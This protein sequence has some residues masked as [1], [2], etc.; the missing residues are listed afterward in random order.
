MILG[1]KEKLVFL[2]LT[3]ETQA[4][5]N[6]QRIPIS[7]SSMSSFQSDTSAPR[8]QDSRSPLI[9]SGLVF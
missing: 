3:I 9:Y 7:T 2:F 8:L 4:I 1:D 5:R 6:K